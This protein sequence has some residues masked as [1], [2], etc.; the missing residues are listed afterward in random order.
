MATY[1]ATKATN[2]NSTYRH[3]LAGLPHAVY[4]T[5]TM[6]TAPANGDVF[7]MLRVP[8]G[9]RI[10][11]CTL[12]ATDIDT[13]ATPTVTLNVGDTDDVDRLIAAATVGQGAGTSS[14]LVSGTGQFYKYSSETI[15]SVQIPTGPATGAIGT[16]ELCVEYVIQD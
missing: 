10:T 3:D 1:T 12:K 11:G 13:N 2:G 8:A 14:A 6:T 4:S 9:A 7:Q 15:I 16:L 5:Y